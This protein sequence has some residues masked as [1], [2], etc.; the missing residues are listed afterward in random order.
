MSYCETG[1]REVVQRAQECRDRYGYPSFVTA[2]RHDLLH[3][4]GCR[5]KMSR[6]AVRDAWVIGETV[7]LVD[8]SPGVAWRM[9]GDWLDW[10]R[11][12]LSVVVHRKVRP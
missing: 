9:R 1:S 11:I 4:G 6:N 7:L 2:M 12:E 8:E 5:V 3:H 10:C